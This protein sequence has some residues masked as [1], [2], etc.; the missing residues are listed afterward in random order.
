MNNSAKYLS[1]MVDSYN[2]LHADYL[3]TDSISEAESLLLRLKAIEKDILSAGCCIE[4]SITEWE[5]Y[6]FNM[7]EMKEY[8]EYALSIIKDALNLVRSSENYNLLDKIY[9]VEDSLLEKTGR[10]RA[11]KEFYRKREILQQVD[12]KTIVK[13]VNFRNF[14]FIPGQANN[15]L[16]ENVKVN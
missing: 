9:A 7:P 15:I 11:M 5:K 3:K 6:L 4:L 13:H 8:G 14:T 1:E 2:T 10:H 16:K 12:N